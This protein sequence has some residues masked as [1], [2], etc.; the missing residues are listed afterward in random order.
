MLGLK[1]K[2]SRFKVE[3][4]PIEGWIMSTWLINIFIYGVVWDMD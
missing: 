3:K 2:G 1:G 4:E